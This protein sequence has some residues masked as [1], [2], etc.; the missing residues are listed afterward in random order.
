[1]RTA[2]WVRRTVAASAVMAGLIVPG[3]IVPGVV[4]PGDEAHA[5]D[6]KAVDVLLDYTIYASGLRV[7]QT[8]ID[9]TIDPGAYSIGLFTEPRGL[10]S[11]LTRWQFQ[12]RSTG[13]VGQGDV[14]DVLP[15]SYETER[16]RRGTA[17][18]FRIDYDDQGPVQEL[19]EPE[20]LLTQPVPEDEK[21]GTL[22][23]LSAT[24]ALIST[25]SLS[26]G[27]PGDLPVYDGRRRFDISFVESET[28]TL[29]ETR[30]S[31]YRGEAI[32]CRLQFSP[33]AGDFDLDDRSSFWYEEAL[34]ER[35]IDMWLA[36]VLGEGA[37]PVPVKLRGTGRYG[38][39]YIHLTALSDPVAEVEP[40][41]EG[42][43]LPEGHSR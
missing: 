6:G 36:P 24:V 7:A 41:I 19:H 1:M 26:E 35:H 37:P 22:D 17:R 16:R 14:G 5:S 25:I 12:A 31:G 2:T 40:P 42:A 43:A 4:L 29:Q 28:V 9:L 13:V 11:L 3:V 27:C 34:E 32:R 8:E 18:R 30:Y 20:K 33:I 38:P 10:V 21:G 23:P 15:L 39:F